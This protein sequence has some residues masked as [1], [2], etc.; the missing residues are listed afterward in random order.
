[1]T[2]TDRGNPTSYYG[3]PVLKEPAWT[4]EV[5][6]YLFA[7]GLAGASSVVA[8]VSGSVGDR[9]GAQ[10]AAWVAAAGAAAS[11]VLLIK[12]LG[13][14]ARFLAMLRV[15]KVTSPLSVGSWILAAYVPAAAGRAAVEA[16]GRFRW[17]VRPLDA[18][19]ALLGTALSVYTGVLLANT[20]IPAWHHARRELPFVFAS[21]SV[22]SAGGAA[23][24][25]GPRGRSA[26][27]ARRLACSGAV[28]ELA[29][30]KAMEHRLGDDVA[31]YRSG[32][33]SRWSTAAKV[34]TGLGAA[35]ALV[36]RPALGRMAGASLLGGSLCLRFAVFKAG[37]TSAG[38][39]SRTVRAGSGAVTR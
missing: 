1:M 4:V 20:A 34:L 25:F 16:T 17:L 8:A 6:W 3:Q 5:P 13:R 18:S 23:L 22:A 36:P 7:G 2:T 14:P 11:P 12:D 29:I 37:F 33:A 31:A 19:A 38:H 32:P 28:G 9:S 30:V 15:F 10:R 35:L 27:I 21:S 39:P 26:T 24:V